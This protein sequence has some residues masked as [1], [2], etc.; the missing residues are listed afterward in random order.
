[1]PEGV[2]KF[3]NHDSQA[4]LKVGLYDQLL[5]VGLYDQRLF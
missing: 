2:L 1:M 4:D 5:N 3:G